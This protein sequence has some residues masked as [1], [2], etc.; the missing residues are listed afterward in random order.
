MDISRKLAYNK[1]FS[2]HGYVPLPIGDT[3]ED[4][5]LNLKSD[6]TPM[7]EGYC[8][9]CGQLIDECTGQQLACVN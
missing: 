2:T 8:P 1:F 3:V 7:A 4:L 6:E 9:G 5:V